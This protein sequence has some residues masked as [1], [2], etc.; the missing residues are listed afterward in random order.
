[1]ANTMKITR[2]QDIDYNNGKHPRIWHYIEEE[3]TSG[4]TSREVEDRT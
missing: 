4:R 3:S 2:Q 1:M